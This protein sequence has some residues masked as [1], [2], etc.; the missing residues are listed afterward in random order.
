MTTSGFSAGTWAYT[1]NFGSGGNQTYNVALSGGT[2]TFDNGATCFD[3]IVGDTVWVTIG[4]TSSNTLTVPGSA[5]PPPPPPATWSETVGGNADTWTNYT[6]AGGTQ[7]PTIPVYNT[8]QISCAI[9]GFGVA[10]GNVWWYRVASSP[11]SNAYY[12]SADAFYN[13]GATS[14][15]L[16]GTPFVDAA[17]PHC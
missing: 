1:C 2:Q 17:V 7:G 15:S 14:G 16:S 3:G 11:W 4:S 5:P 10:D 12:V 6:N 13:N 9:E 8:V